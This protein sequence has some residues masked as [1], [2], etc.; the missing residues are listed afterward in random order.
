MSPLPNKIRIFFYDNLVP[1]FQTTNRKFLI[2]QRKWSIESCY[3]FFFGTTCV[4]DLHQSL[5]L[6]VKIEIIQWKSNIWNLTDPLT[7]AIV[8]Y[9]NHDF[10]TY[11]RKKI[12][13][14]WSEGL[15]SMWMFWWKFHYLLVMSRR[16]YLTFQPLRRSMHFC[17]LDISIFNF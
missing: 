9:K 11:K 16:S 1:I 14:W 13:L 10:P 4:W 17:H 15:T 8:N 7:S 3:H 2:F 5:N 12:P 6:S